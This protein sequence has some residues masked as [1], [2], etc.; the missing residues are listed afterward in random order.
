MPNPTTT[1]GQ[2]LAQFAPGGTAYGAL[3]RY[4]GTSL[5]GVDPN[6][7]TSNR[8][9]ALLR[10]DNPIVGM[11]SDN[12]RSYALARGGGLDSGSMAYNAERGAMEALTPIASEEAG[13]YGN[14][15]A[16]N[17]NALNQHELERMG[18]QTSIGVANIGAR[19]A[20][21]QLRMRNQFDQQQ[22]L[23]SRNWAL[24]DQDTQARAAARSQFIG[25]MEQAIFSDP[26]VWRDPQGALG[27]ITEYSDNFN[28]WF[29]NS[30]PE[31]FQSGENNTPAQQTPYQQ[32]GGG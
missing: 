26:S 25:N 11:A 10:S 7:L 23:Q 30:Y 28:N 31:Y 2:P 21:D 4:G 13:M 9:A 27:M 16:A 24:S 6:M 3:S 15:A 22:A 12:A 1:P 29:A 14:V 8:L 32:G 17:Q 19:S 20:L 5:L 18:N